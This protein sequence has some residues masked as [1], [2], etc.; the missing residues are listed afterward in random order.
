VELV[1]FWAVVAMLAGAAVLA[2]V[3]G[4]LGVRRPRQALFD[5]RKCGHEFRSGALAHFPSRCP[6]CNAPDWNLP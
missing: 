2:F 4:W 6:R 1:P 3:I 5:C